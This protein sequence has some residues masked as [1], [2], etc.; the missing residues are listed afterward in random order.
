M[1]DQEGQVIYLDPALSKNK[2]G[3]TIPL[4]FRELEEVI[5]E[6]WARKAPGCA[7]VFHRY[8]KPM[9]NYHGAWRRFC[10]EVGLSG[11]LFHDF[12]RTAIRNM[13]RAG[14]PERVAMII[15]GHKTRSRI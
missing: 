1:V 8:G 11:M 15:S 14:V 10:K 3:R 13:V 6:Q 12:R 2:E 9:R 7:Y 4:L 5:E